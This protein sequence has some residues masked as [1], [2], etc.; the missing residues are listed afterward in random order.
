VFLLVFFVQIIGRSMGAC[1]NAAV[2][3]TGFVAKS[4]ITERTRRI[5]TVC[6][7]GSGQHPPSGDQAFSFLTVPSG[8]R[9][10]FERP[11]TWEDHECLR[12]SR[13]FSLTS[14]ACHY[15]SWS[16]PFMAKDCCLH[17]PWPV[18]PRDASTLPYLLRG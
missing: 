13:V 18:T 16:G 4:R 7:Y 11:C 14:I 12:F 5:Q 10:H 2:Q 17:S 9:L 8:I 1:T 6:M 3:S 15:P